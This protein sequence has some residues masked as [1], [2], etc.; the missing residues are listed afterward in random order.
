[1]ISNDGFSL[2]GKPLRILSGAIHYFRVP[3][4]YWEDRLAKLCACG[5]NTVLLMVTRSA[6]WD[7]MYLLLRTISFIVR[8]RFGH[9][10]IP[11]SSERSAM[12][13]IWHSSEKMSY[14]N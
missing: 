5:F 14:L 7:P 9:V 10:P 1:M 3:R 4:D 8:H 6:R 11:R 2:E 12:N 13:W